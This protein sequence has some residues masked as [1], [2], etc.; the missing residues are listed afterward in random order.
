MGQSSNIE[1]IRVVLLQEIQL[2]LKWLNS[3]LDAWGALEFEHFLFPFKSTLIS[4]S[5]LVGK[6]FSTKRAIFLLE[7]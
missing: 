1:I 6:Q 2:N 5:V 7:C 4:G 3:D